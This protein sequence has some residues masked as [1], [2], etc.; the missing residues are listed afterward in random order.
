[1]VVAVAFSP[2][3]GRLASASWD[4]TVKLWDSRT[5]AELL[6][7]KGHTGEVHAVCFSPDGSQLASASGD[8]S[9][10]LWDARSE[11]EVRRFRH[12]E[13][14]TEIAFSADSRRLTARDRKGQEVAWELPLATGLGGAPPR[15]RER[16][17]PD[18]RFEAI[19]NGDQVRLLARTSWTQPVDAWAESQA[20]RQVQVPAWHA[21][22]AQAAEQQNDWY[23]AGFHLSQLARYT[24]WDAATHRHAADLWARAGQPQRAALH[25]AWVVWQDAHR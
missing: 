18:G 12:T 15:A 21:Q 1:M 24:P 22:Q 10:K 4:K 13:P 20:R 2:D 7:L 3:G 19:V 16:V 23:A 6:T 5:G 9:V 11:N 8:K 14:I 17:S 25:F